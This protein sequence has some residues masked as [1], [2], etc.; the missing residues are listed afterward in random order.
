MDITRRHLVGSSF[1]LG[2]GL[3]APARAE[4][5]PTRP[6]D[7]G[8]FFPVAHNK[9]VDADLTSI[10]GR[11]GVARGE[12]IEVTGRVLDRDG[13]PVP[14]A[15]L[16][17]WQANA[18]GRYLHKGDTHDAPL[19]MNFQGFAQLKADGDG[20]YRIRTVHPG[21]YPASGYQRA[22]H[23]HFMVDGDNSRLVTQ[24]YFENDPWLAQDQTLIRDLRGKAAP[25]PT[26]IFGVKTA[27]AGGVPVYAWDVVLLYG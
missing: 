12:I 6:M 11:S 24:M 13:K 10:E 2:A 22:S 25:W 3:A 18:A 17:I 27:G 7:L 4:L 26:D 16:D 9:D 5:G 14:G 15:R 1:L 21:Y 19:D 20:R 23:I 8:P